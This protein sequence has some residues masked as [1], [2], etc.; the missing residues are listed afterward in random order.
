M[1]MTMWKMQQAGNNIYGTSDVPAISDMN[2]DGNPEIIIGRA[3]VS[4]TGSMIAAGAYGMGG[5]DYNNV[6]TCSFA[7]DVDGDGQE[8]V[9]TGNAL[10][11]MDGSA[12]CHNGLGDGYPAA[13]DFDH[14]GKAEIVA[15]GEGEIRMIDTDGTLDRKST[16]LNSSHRT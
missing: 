4:N 13:A 15:S 1:M 16:R 14:D 6:G 12:I 2:H 5:V 8:E 11:R 9:V 3:I 10:Y 7:V